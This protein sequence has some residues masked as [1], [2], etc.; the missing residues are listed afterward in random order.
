MPNAKRITPVTA[1]G[2]AG[3]GGTNGMGGT[4]G[5]GGTGGTVQ[6]ALR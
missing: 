2:R 6:G 3:I 4:D 1:P 5:M